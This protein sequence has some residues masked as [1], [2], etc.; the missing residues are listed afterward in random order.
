MLVRIVTELGI[1]EDLFVTV[2]RKSASISETLGLSA[3]GPRG[4]PSG[5]RDSVAGLGVALGTSYSHLPLHIHVALHL[6]SRVLQCDVL[7]Q[8]ALHIES[9]DLGFRYLSSSLTETWR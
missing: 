8:T 1:S 6:M 2:F 9:H 7:Q 5:N 4:G 3:R